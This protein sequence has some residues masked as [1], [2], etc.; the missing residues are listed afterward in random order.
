A[1]GDREIGD[2]R[3]I[4]KTH[5]DGGGDAIAPDRVHAFGIARILAGQGGAAGVLDRLD[6][7]ADKAEKAVGLV[8]GEPARDK[9]AAVGDEGDALIWPR[10][11]D[12]GKATKGVVLA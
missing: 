11:G 1:I 12:A 2:P 6:G 10:L 7:D 5:A 3:Q 9:L 8:I 4:L